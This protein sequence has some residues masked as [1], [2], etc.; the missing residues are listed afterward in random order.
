M[1]VVARLIA[2]NHLLVV[3]FVKTCETVLLKVPVGALE[4]SLCR[5]PVTLKPSGPEGI[6]SFAALAQYLAEV[7]RLLVPLVGETVIVCRAE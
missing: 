2:D 3:E 1:V 6:D 7:L 5:L 4:Q